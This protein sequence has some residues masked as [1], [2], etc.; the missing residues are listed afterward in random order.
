MG[1]HRS[2]ATSIVAIALAIGGCTDP[3][4]PAEGLASA[5]ARWSARG[6][7]S[8]DMTL[9]RPCEC[10]PGTSGVVAISVRNGVVVSRN[11]PNGAPVPAE[12]AGSFPAIPDLFD[13]ID[14]AI[15]AGTRPLDVRYDA[16]YGYPIRAALGDVAADAPLY[17][18]T[19]FT[20]R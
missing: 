5:R 13:I 17:E 10:L 9:G 11:Y 2:V 7:A 14:G 18:I 20:P 16:L 19:A 1:R 15:R 6:P 3:A 8:Y 4:S 12:Y